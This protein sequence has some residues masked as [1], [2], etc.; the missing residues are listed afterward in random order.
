M[1]PG[2]IITSAL[3][4]VIGLAI[5]AVLVSRNAQTGNVLTSAGQALGYVIGQAVS[6][7]TQTGS[8]AGLTNSI[9]NA[10]ADPFT[11]AGAINLGNIAA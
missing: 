7:V 9:G 2:V 1:H 11:S 3:A 4:L 5:V 6:P 8:G 10:L